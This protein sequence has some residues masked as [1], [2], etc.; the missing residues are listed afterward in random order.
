KDNL[1]PPA[2]LTS[3][4]MTLPVARVWSAALGGDD[5][6]RVALAPVIDGERVFAAGNHGAVVAFSLEDGRRL[7]RTDT[8]TVLSG[9]P[10]LGAGL[11]VVGSSDGEVIALDAETG[12]ERWRSVVSS[13]V[14]AAPVIANQIVL[15]R[16]GD[17][18]VTALDAADGGQL[19]QHEQTMPSLVLRGTAG[20][21]VADDV[22]IVG[23]DNGRVNALRVRDGQV[24]WETPVA[25]P[26][27]RTEIE[28]MVDVNA[29]PRVIG[30][31]IYAVAYQGRIAAMALES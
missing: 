3:Y 5:D 8:R 14:L 2:E 4:D 7:W 16:G 29:T 23:Y 1:E 9:G 11:L 13:E 18:R 22:A 26:S 19:W 24:V 25:S 15:V 28:R 6:A 20:I 17:E 30:R 31:D 10:G 12:V 27:G 21:V